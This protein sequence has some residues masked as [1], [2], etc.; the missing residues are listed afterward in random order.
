[1]QVLSL[2]DSC[3]QIRLMIDRYSEAPD[4]D[5][6]TFLDGYLISLICQ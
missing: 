5:G 1:M 2:L 3:K 6:A 4:A